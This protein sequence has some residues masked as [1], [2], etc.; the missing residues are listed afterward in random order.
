MRTVPA[1][2]IASL[3]ILT[4]AV[5]VAGCSSPGDAGNTTVHVLV[6]G[7][8]TPPTFQATLAFATGPVRTLVC[9]SSASAGQ[10][11]TCTDGGFD[12]VTSAGSSFEVTL[13]SVGNV[14]S[15]TMVN[16]SANPP[17]IVLAAPGGVG[18][19]RRLRHAPRRRRLSR[20][21]PG[22]GRAVLDRCGRQLLGEVLH[23][24][25]QDRAQG[26]LSE[27]EE[28]P[29][30]FD[31]AATGPR[32]PRDGGRLRGRN[33]LRRRSICDGRHPHPLSVGRRCCGRRHAF[34]SGTMD[35][36]FLSE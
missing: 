24:R 32:D 4:F 19:H 2:P 9:P 10:T 11:Q 36:Q 21:P 7:A 31:F 22:V 18:Q 20:R 30:H 12:V 33:L 16:A 5:M 8:G 27:H 15:T 25:P 35:A 6:Q 13:R 14:F 34:R 29:L 3:A 17:T 28:A 1:V 23:A 26:L